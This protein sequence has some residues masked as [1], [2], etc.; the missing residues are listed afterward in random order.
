M[1]P[2]TNLQASWPVHVG[3][4]ALCCSPEQ[5]GEGSRVGSKEHPHEGTG[6]NVAFKMKKMQG[7]RSKSVT[8]QNQE[9]IFVSSPSDAILG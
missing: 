2:A 4:P 5:T 1:D 8:P 7:M 9:L 6:T 3:S